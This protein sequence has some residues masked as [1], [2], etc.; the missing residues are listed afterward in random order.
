MRYLQTNNLNP[1]PHPLPSW[2]INSLKI[3]MHLTFNPSTCDG[4]HTPGTTPCS[5]DTILTY[6]LYISS[7]VNKIIG[8]LHFKY[9]S[10][11]HSSLISTRYTTHCYKRYV[12]AIFILFNRIFKVCANIAQVYWREK[13]ISFFMTDC[14]SEL[15]VFEAAIFFHDLIRLHILG[16][17]AN[18]IKNKEQ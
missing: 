17:Y 12:V 6:S 8:I 16:K 2:D 14:H 18:R 7:F 9:I 15:D 1:T 13:R 11:T 3:K 4:R 10:L 5:I